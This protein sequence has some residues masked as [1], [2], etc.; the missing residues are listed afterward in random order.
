MYGVGPLSDEAAFDLGVQYICRLSGHMVWLEYK[1][2][3]FGDSVT[4]HRVTTVENLNYPLEATLG[5]PGRLIKSACKELKKLI[6]AE[7]TRNTTGPL[8]ELGYTR[9]CKGLKKVCED[10]R[11]ILSTNSSASRLPAKIKASALHSTKAQAW[12]VP[13]GDKKTSMSG[14]TT[15]DW[16]GLI[17]YPKQGYEYNASQLLVRMKFEARIS[18][19]GLPKNMTKIFWLKK[20]KASG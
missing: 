2:E 4:I 7:I 13:D 1:D 19:V 5:E 9:A 17:H 6:E 14:Q 20:L 18:H 8:D 11:E 12:V 16:L 10:L 15:R 3:N